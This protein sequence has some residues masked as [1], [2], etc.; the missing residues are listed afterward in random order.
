MIQLVSTQARIPGKV[1]CD[2]CDVAMNLF[3]IER[4]PIIDRTDLRT[5]VCPRCDEEKVEAVSVLQNGLPVK[6]NEM[7]R[8]VDAPFQSKAFDAETTRLLGS[9][10]DAGWEA[11]T[12]SGDLVADPQQLI[13]LREL[14]AKLLIE[15]VQQG[16]R[17]PGR[18]LENA[19]GRSVLSQP[20]SA[21]LPT[22]PQAGTAAD[23]G[24]LRS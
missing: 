10:F 21:E 18:L 11:I 8:S 12:A 7:L 3:G 1:K 5:Y 13:L 19:L 4:H 16:E 6:E 23:A 14:F 15:M 17:N 2:A 24:L 9:T 22:A 20:D